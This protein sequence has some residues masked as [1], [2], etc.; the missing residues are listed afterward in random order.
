VP[1]PGRLPAALP[2][3]W[4]RYPDRVVLGLALLVAGA[5][6]IAGSNVFVLW[7]AGLG[8]L[9]HAAGWAILPAAGWRR[10]VA[11]A[12]GT[13]L[14]LL[15]LAG[16][17][18]V[19]VVVV[20]FLAWLLARHRPA[21]VWFTAVFPAA[22]ATIVGATAPPTGGMLPALAIMGAVLA[23]SAWIAAY[24]SSGRFGAASGRMRS[25]QRPADS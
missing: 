23:G 6:A 25:R 20:S 5:V 17:H 9:A 1:D 18:Y 16:P 13:P 2:L 21:R 19:G 10:I 7:L 12:V 22:G 11:A 4:G 24:L 3:R 8:M 14:T 15:L